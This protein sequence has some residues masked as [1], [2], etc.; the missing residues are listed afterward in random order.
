M[1]IMWLFL[2]AKDSVVILDLVKRAGV[3]YDAHYN[4]T[5]VDPPELVQFI[6]REYPEVG[7]NMPK[8]SMWQLIE[9]KHFPPL[10]QQRYCC[11]YLKE[12]G[13]DGRLV[14]TGVRWAESSKRSKRRSVE[15]CLRGGSKVYINIIIDW[16][17]EDV[18]KY[19]K[20][21]KIKY[22]KLYNEG[23]KRLGCV[24]CPMSAAHMQKES[25]RWPKIANAY[26]RAINKAFTARA[27]AGKKNM[28]ASGDELYEWW[29]SG[30]G[31]K[32]DPDQ[33][34]LFE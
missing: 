30:K 34:V 27:A 5:T 13:G 29:I 2:G 17:D 18:W 11:Q 33:G 1:A 31:N 22:C 4:V 19:I 32:G 25:K 15:Q 26:K 8:M 7:W 20:D 16:L 28:F 10:R 6:K 14:V 9:H 3:K 24:M 23:F 12:N 21:N